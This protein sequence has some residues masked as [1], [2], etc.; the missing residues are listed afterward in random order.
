MSGWTVIVCEP[1]REQKL[2][3]ALADAGR[4]AFAPTYTAWKPKFGRHGKVTRPLIQGYVFAIIEPHEIHDYHSEG[5]VRL[6]PTCARSATRL[7][8]I[9]EDWREAVDAGLFDEPEPKAPRPPK[10]PARRNRKV[11]RLTGQAKHK[12]AEYREGLEAILAE[13]TTQRVGSEA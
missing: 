9:I 5:A 1:Q 12:A 4:E 7:A 10:I 13:M 2:R 11:R 8:G 6:L 3:A